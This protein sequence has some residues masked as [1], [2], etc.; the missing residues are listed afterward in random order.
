MSVLER[1]LNT[2][3]AHIALLEEMKPDLVA[4]HAVVERFIATTTPLIPSDEAIIG[5]LISQNEDLYQELDGR[6]LDLL[7]YITRL[8]SSNKDKE[9][10]N[11]SRISEVFATLN[12]LRGTFRNGDL[13]MYILQLDKVN[14]VKRQY[15]GSTPPSLHLYLLEKQML[16]SFLKKIRLMI[17]GIGQITTMLNAHDVFRSL[18][19]DDDRRESKLYI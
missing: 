2:R 14:K 12:G 13:T 17:C 9:H 18:T 10:S 4:F 5:P 1:P 8:I 19:T 15:P 6:F 3:E 11:M 16:H 7:T